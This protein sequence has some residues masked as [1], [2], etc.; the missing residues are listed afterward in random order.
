[1][2]KHQATV[3]RQH[4]FNWKKPQARPSLMT[5]VGI[6]NEANIDSSDN[7]SN[8]TEVSEGVPQG[9]ILGLLLI[10]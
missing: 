2:S 3:V 5:L 1:M 9:S 6:G 4:P 8:A 7:K 10:P